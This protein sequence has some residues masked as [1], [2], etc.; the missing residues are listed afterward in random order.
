[1]V[2]GATSRDLHFTGVGFDGRPRLRH[3]YLMSG[4]SQGET[5]SHGFFYRPDGPQSGVLGLPVRAAGRPGYEQLY[6]GSASIVFLRDQDG[7]FDPLGD[8][9]A[10]Q[11]KAPADGCKAS[12]VDWYGNARPI[13]LGQRVFAL[14]GY[15]LVEGAAREGRLLEI[16]R[17]DFSPRVA[18]TA[19]R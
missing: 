16:G 7:R 4:A 15:E 2:I 10:E 1:V 13:F 5:R 11:Q 3:H 12:C 14:L 6:D 8:L 18:R 9:R 17:T 19:I